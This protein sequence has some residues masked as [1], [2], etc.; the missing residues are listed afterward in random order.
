MQSPTTTNYVRQVSH[1]W[2]NCRGQH[3]QNA[4]DKPCPG[5][6]TFVILVSPLPV[7]RPEAVLD[8]KPVYR[9]RG[10]VIRRKKSAVPW[11]VA[12]TNGCTAC[13]YASYDMVLRRLVRCKN[14][15]QRSSSTNEC[16]PL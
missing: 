4:M 16:L 11:Q 8:L 12:K 1:I 9:R 3:I 15:T 2:G 5:K 10:R 7:S 14:P 6:T 13:S